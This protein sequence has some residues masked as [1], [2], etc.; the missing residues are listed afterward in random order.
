MLKPED[1][2]LM[3]MMDSMEIASDK[4]LMDEEIS[5]IRSVKGK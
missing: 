1:E 2:E 4:M 3:K 5:S